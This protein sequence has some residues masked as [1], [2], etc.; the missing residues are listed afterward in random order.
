MTKENSSPFPSAPRSR[1]RRRS[2]TSTRVEKAAGGERGLR[3]KG[4]ITVKDIQK[5]LKY[6]NAP[7][8]NK[9]VYA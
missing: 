9:G 5:K 3:L 4:L 7:R 1:K 2:C 8:M 6:P